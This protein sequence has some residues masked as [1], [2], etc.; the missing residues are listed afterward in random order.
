MTGRL[1][2]EAAA[3][4]SQAAHQPLPDAVRVK[5]TWHV[6]DSVAAGISG[7]ALLAGR[8]GR[9][10]A[11]A[12]GGGAAPLWG[13][14]MTAGAPIAALANGMSCHADETDDSHARSIS[15][16][17]AS[18]VPAAF[19]VAAGRA[20]SGEQLVRAVVAGYD[21]GPRVTMAL[22]TDRFQNHPSHQSSHALAGTFGS[23]AAACVLLA[24]DSAGAEV[25]LSYAAQM[26]SGVS[27]F[28]RDEAHVQ[29]AFVFAGQPAHN[30]VLA[31]TFADLGWEGVPDAFD[32]EPNFFDA[33]AAD[34]HAELIVD[35]LGERFEIMNT[36]IK[37][38]AVGSPAQAAVQ[39]AELLINRDDLRVDEIDSIQIRLPANAAWVVDDR[40]MPDINVQYLVAGTFLGGRF[41]FGM[42]HDE[43]RMSDPTVVDLRS[44]TTLIADEATAGTRSGSV[45]VTRTDGT[46]I[47]ADVPYVRGTSH[48]PMDVGEIEAKAMDLLGPVIGETQAKRLCEAILN[49]EAI[50]DV[51][52]LSPLMQT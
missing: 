11:V 31:A 7:S 16:P 34:N 27:T 24:L 23:T 47:R 6:L 5:A 44:R 40:A 9:Q 33:I 15:H 22:G 28:L 21:L 13:S 3:Y 10:Y 43:A 29:K 14:T 37:K 18:I 38:Y 39:A 19:A 2:K 17:G 30:G 48:D 42:A 12:A 52:V 32:G 26:C 41:T 4:L 46:V 51:S 25:A 20:V 49:L 35:A 45:L 36:N 50:A 8:R 1:T